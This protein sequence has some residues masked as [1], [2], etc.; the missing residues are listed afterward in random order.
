MPPVIAPIL[1]A[2]IKVLSNLQIDIHNAPQDGRFRFPIEPIC[3]CSRFGIPT[4]HGEKGEMRLLK[5][6]LRPLTLYERF[7]QSELP[8]IEMAIKKPR[9]MI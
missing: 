3:R 2:R 7:S 9:G 6:S 1:I 4:F 8:K 5:G